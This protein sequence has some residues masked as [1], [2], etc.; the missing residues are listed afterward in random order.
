M[1]WKGRTVIF[2]MAQAVLL[3][4][5]NAEFLLRRDLTNLNK[6]FRRLGV[7]V[8][9]VDECYKRVTGVVKS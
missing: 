2:D 5:P 7:N 3:V 4:H 9:S 6:Y 1:M 8:P